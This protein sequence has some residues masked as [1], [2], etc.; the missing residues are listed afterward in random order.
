MTTPS[1]LSGLVVGGDHACAIEGDDS[2]WCW[3]NNDFG[4]LGAGG[5]GPTPVRTAV[6][7]P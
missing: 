1:G 6:L 7:C 2:V 5:P 3:G 4:Q